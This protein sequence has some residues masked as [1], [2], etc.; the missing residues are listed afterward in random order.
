MQLLVRRRVKLYMVIRR[1]WDGM[2]YQR[3]YPN[4]GMVQKIDPESYFTCYW[5]GIKNLFR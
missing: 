5:D 1:T 4:H 3:S 2:G